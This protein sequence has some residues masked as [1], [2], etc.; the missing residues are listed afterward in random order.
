[1]AVS[2]SQY[3]HVHSEHHRQHSNHYL[4]FVTRNHGDSDGGLTPYWKSDRVLRLHV[5]FIDR[6]ARDST[7]IQHGYSSLKENQSTRELVQ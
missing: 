4:V 5:F 2:V 7:Q 1:M 6:R 3:V